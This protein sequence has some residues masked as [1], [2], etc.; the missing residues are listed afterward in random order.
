[1]KRLGLIVA[2]VAMAGLFACTNMTPQQQGTM[3]GA[4]IGAAGR[5]PASRP[6]P[7]ATRGPARRSAALPAAWPAISGATG[8]N[9]AD[10]TRRGAAEREAPDA[11]REGQPRGR[12]RAQSARPNGTPKSRR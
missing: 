7:A 8:S 12:R 6:S 1:M 10:A 2:I 3:S 9:D 4:A 5:G 11:Q